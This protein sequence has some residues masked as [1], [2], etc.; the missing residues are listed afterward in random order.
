MTARLF[1]ALI[2]ANL[3]KTSSNKAQ[4][5]DIDTESLRPAA[6]MLNLYL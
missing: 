2:R 4:H 5:F 6:K 3:A 1:R